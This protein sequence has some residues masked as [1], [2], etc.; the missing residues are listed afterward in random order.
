MRL[1]NNTVFK[2]LIMEI[3]HKSIRRRGW[4]QQL[5]NNRRCALCVCFGKRSSI[6]QIEQ[7]SR[8]FLVFLI[9]IQFVIGRLM[10]Q[11]F[12]VCCM[13]SKAIYHTVAIS[14]SISTS[15]GIE[16]SMSGSSP[17]RY[18]GHKSCARRP[19]SRTA[20]AACEA[21]SLFFQSSREAQKP[22]DIKSE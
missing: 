6:E 4:D 8:R 18:V 12:Y 21:R 14:E 5:L 1:D 3:Y 10:I 19:P 11:H 9:C 13:Y 17:T 16:T 22:A 2:R 20:A 7:N 15:S